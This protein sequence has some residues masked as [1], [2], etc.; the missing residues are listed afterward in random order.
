[1]HIK[2]KYGVKFFGVLFFLGI[3]MSEAI[4]CPC[5]NN[6]FLELT[7]GNSKN[8]KCII[9][10]NNNYFYKIDYFY[11]AEISDVKYIASSTYTECMLNTAHH[12]VYMNFGRMDFSIQ[13][14]EDHHECIDAIIDACTNLHIILQ[15][16]SF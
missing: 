9:Y 5:F 6:A 11:K 2:N 7:F 1:M 12:D 3:S 13:N 14:I 15:R 4:A 10:K 8:T 16:K